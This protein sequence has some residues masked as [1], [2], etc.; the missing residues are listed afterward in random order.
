MS[1]TDEDGK[2]ETT[3]AVFAVVIKVG[4]KCTAM[5]SSEGCASEERRCGLGVDRAGKSVASLPYDK[6]RA[7][8][9]SPMR[10]YRSLAATCLDAQL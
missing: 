3:R 5:L 9:L 4:R 6:N 8:S 1:A 2:L 7:C 10:P